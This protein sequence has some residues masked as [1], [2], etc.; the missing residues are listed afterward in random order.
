LHQLP[1]SRSSAVTGLAVARL[2]SERTLSHRETTVMNRP[3]RDA[4]CC[5]DDHVDFWGTRTKLVTTIEQRRSG[6]R[7]IKFAGVLDEHARL[8]ELTAQVGT[9]VTLINLAGVERINSSGT[10]DWV[11]W[12]EALEANGARPALIACSPAVVAQLNRIKNFAHHAVVK[13]FQVPYHCAACDADK[14]LLV[15]IADMGEAPHSAPTC[16]CNICERPMELADESGNY[17]AFVSQV[18]SAKPELREPDLA[19]GSHSTFTEEDARPSRPLLLRD[20]RPLLS[21]YQFPAQRPSDRE[22][23]RVAVSEPRLWLFALVALLVCTIAVLLVL[24]V[25]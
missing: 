12:L 3:W 2:R 19:R 18:Q 21:V 15:H 1:V 11:N 25:M 23:P 5:S 24:L 9:G 6:A 8:A 7:V 13:S 4:L 10:R 14:L 22:L 20:T 16:T 17:F